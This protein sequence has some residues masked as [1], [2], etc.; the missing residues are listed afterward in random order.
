ML[1][2]IPV[3]VQQFVNWIFFILDS[4][5]IPWQIAVACAVGIGLGIAA[6]FRLAIAR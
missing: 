5:G 6:A 2:P 4:Q 3:W 1:F